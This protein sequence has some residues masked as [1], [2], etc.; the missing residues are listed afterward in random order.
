MGSV[1]A[2]QFMNNWLL[3]INYPE[4]YVGLTQLPLKTQVKFSQ[5]RFTLTMINEDNENTIVSPYE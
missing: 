5:Q 3:Q 4:V 1:T 2:E